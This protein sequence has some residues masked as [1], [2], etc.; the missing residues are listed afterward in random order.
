MYATLHTHVTFLGACANSFFSCT[1][2]VFPY[3]NSGVLQNQ[4]DEKA[5]WTENI[6]RLGY[7][8]ETKSNSAQAS[9]YAVSVC[10]N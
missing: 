5:N 1:Y 7:S 4:I 2:Y 3:I 9:N 10:S 6:M 8:L